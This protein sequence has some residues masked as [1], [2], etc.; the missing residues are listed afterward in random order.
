[1]IGRAQ[2]W[3]SRWDS[4]PR[5]REV[6]RFSRPPRYDRF[7]TAPYLKA[8][9]YTRI[10]DGLQAPLSFITLSIAKIFYQSVE[11]HVVFVVNNDTA[12]ACRTVEDLDLNLGTELLL[13]LC[14][15]FL[16]A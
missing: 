7:D 8:L 15:N 9:K 14:L 10:S 1:M 12:S 13:E 6:K 11:V 5:D 4:N 3:R 2:I 16:C